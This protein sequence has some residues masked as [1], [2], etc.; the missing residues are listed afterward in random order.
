MAEEIT[1]TRENFEKEVKQSDIPVLVDFWAP[2]C[3]P[4]NMIAPFLKN[5]AEKYDGKLKVGRVNVDEQND[6]AGQFGI[7]SIPT[8][9]VFNKGEVIEKKIGAVSQQTIEDMFKSV[10]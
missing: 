10:I 7:V 4:C 5:I 2:W 9:I 1:V 3:M 6:L 8:L